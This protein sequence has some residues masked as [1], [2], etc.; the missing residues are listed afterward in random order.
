MFTSSEFKRRTGHYLNEGWGMTETSPAATFTPLVGERRNGSCGLPMPGITHQHAQHRRPVAPGAAWRARRDVRG[1]PEGDQG[2]LEDPEATAEAMTA[3]GF[4]RTGDV[5]IMAEDGFVAI[6][7]RSKDMI[8]CAGF[9]VYPRNVE[10][11][12]QEHPAVAEVGVIG[13]HDEYSGQVPKAFVSLK[14]GAAPFTLDELKAFLKDK[15]GKQAMVRALEIR[16]KLPKTA[17][18]KLSKKDLY[19]EE[20]RRRASIRRT[21]R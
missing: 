8:P 7:D 19:D 4:L 12:I 20:Q 5:A 6:V 13:I 17:V 9:N 1:R 18:G 2:L 21:R 15:L 16:A 14:R 10:A 11:A 3:D